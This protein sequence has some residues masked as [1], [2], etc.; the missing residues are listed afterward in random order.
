[1][2]AVSKKKG[3]AF[4][5]PLLLKIIQSFFIRIQDSESRYQNL[6][7]QFGFEAMATN[8]V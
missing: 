6:P 5:L 7:S 3:A 8:G 4:Q 1:M 2:T